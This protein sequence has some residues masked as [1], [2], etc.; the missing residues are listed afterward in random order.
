MLN[1][2]R[3]HHQTLAT[4]ARLGVPRPWQRFL[5]SSVELPGPENKSVVLPR[6]PE[7]LRDYRRYFGIPD[8]AYPGELPPHLFAQWTLGPALRTLLGLPYPMHRG[9]NGGCE[10]ELRGPLPVDVPL[11]LNTQLESIDADER[12]VLFVVIAKSGPRRQPDALTAKLTFILPRRHSAAK[13]QPARVPESAEAIEHFTLRSDAGR[14][15][16]QLTGDF[17][18]IH[19]WRPYA[20]LMGH[21][22]VIL[23]GY[24][25]LGFAME[26]L[27]QKRLAGDVRRLR[28]LDVRFTAPLVLPGSTELFV[29]GSEIYLGANQ[30]ERATLTGSFTAT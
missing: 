27:V 8:D 3:W 2:L 26:A 11:A 25:Q 30:G 20:R 23:H 19:W 29:Q 6:P 9:L 10:L 18:P 16:A 7:L 4:L 5:R 17:N 21:K 14:R 28:R 13:K 12:R 1:A 24:A 15:F 22:S